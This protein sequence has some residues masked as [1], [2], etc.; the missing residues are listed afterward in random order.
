MFEHRLQDQNNILSQFKE[1][2]SRK[3]EENIKLT[4]K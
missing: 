2:T 3:L 1:D 4:L